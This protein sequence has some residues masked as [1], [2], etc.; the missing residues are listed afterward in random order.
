MAK[1]KKSFLLYCDFINIFTELTDQEAGKLIKHIFDYVNDKNPISTNKVIKIAFEPIKLQLKRDLKAWEE[2]RSARSEAGKKGMANRWHN[3]VKQ[4]ITKDNSVIPVI[5]NIT[6]TVTDT[7]NVIQI[8]T[9]TLTDHEIGKTIEFCSITLRREYTS[10]RVAE[11]WEAFLINGQKK[12]HS[13]P[14]K[15]KHF[16]NWIKTQPDETHKRFNPG[17]TKTKLGT[18]DARIEALKS[19]PFGESGN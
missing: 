1:D 6:D 2:E 4:D 5:T 10:A 3:S 9:N 13:L 19:W 14:E 7:D 15:I 17:S 16:R 12:F 8:N 11:L 18:S